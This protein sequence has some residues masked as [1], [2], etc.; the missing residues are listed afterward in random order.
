LFA[1]PSTDPSP[2]DASSGRDSLPSP[3]ESLPPKNLSASRA[4]ASA[5]EGTILQWFSHWFQSFRNRGRRAETPPPEGTQ[6]TPPEPALATPLDFATFI[7]RYRN[8]ESV[9]RMRNDDA[10]LVV[11]LPLRSIGN[12]Q[13]LEALENLRKHVVTAAQRVCSSTRQGGRE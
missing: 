8:P 7:Q 11:C 4:D 12:D 10:T 2:V 9:L 13:N 6:Q 3:S 5:A 1:P